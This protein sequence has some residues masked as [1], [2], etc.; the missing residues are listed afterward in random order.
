V[1]G[2]GLYSIWFVSVSSRNNASAAFADVLFPVS[3]GDIAPRLGFKNSAYEL[4]H[5]TH[6]YIP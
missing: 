5:C 1:L 3:R 2:V 4:K 6:I